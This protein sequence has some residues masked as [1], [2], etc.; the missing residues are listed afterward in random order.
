MAG[1][2]SQGGWNLWMGPASPWANSLA[3]PEV[4]PVLPPLQGVARAMGEGIRLRGSARGGGIAW[5]DP[6][7]CWGQGRTGWRLPGGTASLRPQ[8]QGSRGRRDGC[9]PQSL[10]HLRPLVLQELL[11]GL[12]LPPGNPGQKPETEHGPRFRLRWGPGR[13]LRPC[14]LLRSRP[15]AMGTADRAGPPPTWPRGAPAS[16]T[17]SAARPGEGRGGAWRAPAAFIL[18]GPLPLPHPHSALDPAFWETLWQFPL[19]SVNPES[20]AHRGG[21]TSASDLRLPAR[22][23]PPPRGLAEHPSPDSPPSRRFWA[24]LPTSLC[25]TV[26][27]AM[28][29]GS[30]PVQSGRPDTHASASWV[31]P[32]RSLQPFGILLGGAVQGTVGGPNSIP[33]PH[34]P[35]AKSSPA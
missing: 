11:F 12:P 1:V 26:S 35:D 34:P 15:V 32:H 3:S 6:L 16:H 20:A 2:C 7:C 31:S 10:P 21:P 18:R 33:G 19:T 14:F 27:Q 22:H 13:S 8:S 23:V 5:D 17:W 30:P 4:R 24:P 29:T 9:G 25:R 28:D